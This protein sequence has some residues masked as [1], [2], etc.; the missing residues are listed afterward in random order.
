[1]G[2]VTKCCKAEKKESGEFSKMSGADQFS[3]ILGQKKVKRPMYVCAECGR[4]VSTE[5]SLQTCEE[6]GKT[7][8]LVLDSV[9]TSMLSGMPL[10]GYYHK[11]CLVPARKDREKFSQSMAKQGY[12]TRNYMARDK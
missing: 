2:Y 10:M 7:G 4:D 6:C 11:K 5:Q 8:R 1:M 9:G 12:E 3:V